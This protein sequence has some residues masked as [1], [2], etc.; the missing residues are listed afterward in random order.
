MYITLPSNTTDFPSN[1]TANFRVRLPNPIELSG[2]W[3]VALV[4]IQY[5]YS[6]NNLQD[7]GGNEFQ[8]DLLSKREQLTLVEPEEIKVH[9]GYYKNAGELIDAIKLGIEKWAPGNYIPPKA[10][11]NGEILKRQVKRSDKR[12]EKLRRK[13]DKG[14]H[15]SYNELSK[16]VQISLKTGHIKEVSLGSQLQYMLGF[17][18]EQLPLR[19]AVNIASFP[20]DISAAFNT[21]YI[22][23]DIIQPQV[24]ANSLVPLLRTVPIEGKFGESVDKVFVAPHYLPVRSKRFDSVEISIKTDTNRPVQ[25]N[26][27]KAIIKLHL[28]KQKL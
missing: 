16:R 3:E 13:V 23:S 19:N 6:W 27:G 17:A 5:P 25:F 9:P 7:G 11:S 22:Y 8:V 12:K 26:F 28:R 15:I 10:K 20:P 21:L 2:E 4:E 18:K 14:F 1:N 24:V